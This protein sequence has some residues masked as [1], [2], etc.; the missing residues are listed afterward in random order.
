MLRTGRERRQKFASAKVQ[1]SEDRA[2]N[3]TK[4]G[5]MLI[6]LCIAVCNYTPYYI[7]CR[8]C[9]ANKYRYCLII[10][11]VP[12]AVFQY[13]IS[14]EDDRR[15]YVWGLASHG[16][17][18]EAKALRKKPD[19]VS[20]IERPRRLSFAERY[21]VVDIACGYGFTAY[22]VHSSDKNIVYGTGINTDSQLG[23]Y[24]WCTHC[25]YRRRS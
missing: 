14:Q 16:A 23:K 25:I 24:G 4:L 8:Y 18:G 20:Y 19:A 11:V 13:P 10:F 3:F 22:A 7:R 5:Q 12:L 6:I 1:A 17:L 21:K 2:E 9:R 15:V